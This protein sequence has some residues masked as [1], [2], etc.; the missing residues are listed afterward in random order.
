MHLPLIV[1]ATIPSFRSTTGRRLTTAGLLATLGLA[2]AHGSTQESPASRPLPA[3]IAAGDSAWDTGRRDD[4]FAAYEQVVRRDSTASSRTVFRLATLLSWRGDLARAAVLHRLYV[5]LEPRDDEGRLALARVLSWDGRFDDALV[6]YDSILA[7]DRS[8]RAAALA[9]GEV[10]SWAGRWSVALG[11]YQGWLR[12]HPTDIDAE[13]GLARTL[14]WA[15]RLDEAERRYV[16]IDTRLG[17]RSPQAEKG[18]ARVA[19]WR[20]DLPRSERLWRALTAKYPDDAEA[21]TGLAQVLR[22]TGRPGP[23]EQALNR[24]LSAQ[25][26]YGDARQQLQ[27]VR[28]D[29]ATSLEP[30]VTYT[31]DSDHN[32]STFVSVAGGIAPPWTGR[33]ILGAGYRDA[34]L[35]PAS[36]TGRSMNARAVASWTPFA[37][38]AVLRGEAGLTS[39]R[40]EQAGT[41]TTRTRHTLAGRVAA[42]VAPGVSLGAGLSRTPFDETA[43]LIAGGI[44][45]TALDGDGSWSLP[46][47][48]TLSGGGGYATVTGGS[49]RNYRSSGSAALRWIWR[50]GVSVSTALRTFGYAKVAGDGYFAPK[51]YRLLEASGRWEAPHDLGWLW[52]V[53]GGVGPQSVNAFGATNNR[54]A[55]RIALSLVYRPAPGLEWGA[56]GGFTNVAAPSSVSAAEY[57]AWTLG[58]RGRWS[59]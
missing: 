24:A 57:R 32:R 19:A 58:V 48:L 41:V 36:S 38:A 28:A 25:P 18:I 46:R 20:G 35:T 10:L 40:G 3:L 8:Y 17:G 45:L 31:N 21:W 4:A 6:L 47:R 55:E 34:A 23:A 50:R 52:G 30:S 43:T 7:R 37:R 11:T 1:P 12:E 27:W 22:W 39:L 9:K 49:V 59:F 13:L 42:D 14:S 33:L 56:S 54:L 16:A 5:R 26:G 51:R 2:P 29:L 15:G 44:V 53:D